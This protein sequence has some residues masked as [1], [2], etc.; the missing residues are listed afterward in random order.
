LLSSG[1]HAFPLY[2]AIIHLVHA[3][4]IKFVMGKANLTEDDVKQIV[5][6]FGDQGEIIMTNLMILGFI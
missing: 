2:P 5:K 6:S 4:I 1:W 3:G